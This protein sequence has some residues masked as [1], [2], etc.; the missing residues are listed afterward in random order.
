[1]L[2]I[3]AKIYKQQVFNAHSKT[4]LQINF[5]GIPDHREVAT[6]SFFL[7]ETKE[8]ILDFSDNVLKVV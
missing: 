3:I 7:E 2:T 1:M 4:I 6:E 5:I 8:T